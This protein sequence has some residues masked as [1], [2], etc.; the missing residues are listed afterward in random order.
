MSSGLSQYAIGVGKHLDRQ[1][2]DTLSYWMNVLVINGSLASFYRDQ[3]GTGNECGYV[4]FPRSNQGGSRRLSEAAIA[5]VVL[6]PVA[7][8][9][10]TLYLW[11]L[12]RFKK[13]QSRYKKRF[14]QQVA[15]N[16]SIGRRPGCLAPDKISEEIQLIGQGKESITKDDLAEWMHDIKMN[17]NSKKDFDALWNATDIDGKGEVDAVEFIVFLSACGPEFEVVYSEHEKLPENERLKLAARRLSNIVSCG[18][19]GVRRFERNLERGSRGFVPSAC[20]Y[21]FDSFEV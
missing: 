7:A 15:R 2:V 10:V 18:E 6:G 9:V 17:F 5:G 19:A 1:V 8:L 13:Q 11:H 3:G 21:W 4:L 12:Y 14:V 20:Q 16:I